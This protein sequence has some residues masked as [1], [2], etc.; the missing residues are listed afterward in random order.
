MKYTLKNIS[1][2]P[3]SKK[4]QEYLKKHNIELRRLDNG[5]TIVG[6][7][8]KMD[9]ADWASIEYSFNTGSHNNLP[10]QVH[11]LEHFFNKKIHKLAEKNDININAY[12]S[13]VGV[14]QTSKG[15]CNPNVTNFGIWKT[16]QGVRSGLENPIDKDSKI[17]SE[18]KVIAD[19]IIRLKNN[20]DFL[21][22]R[23]FRQVVYSKEN[24]LFD[25]PL[26]TG[27]LEDLE[28]IDF[29][30]LQ[31]ITEKVLVPDGMVIKIY[32][33]GDKYASKMLADR[34]ENLYLDFP[35]KNKKSS[36]LDQSLRDKLNPDFKPGQIYIQNTN[37]K[38]NRI[39]FSFVWVFK[40]S[41]P[42]I[43]RFALG[44]I[45]SPLF[46]NLHEYSRIAGWGYQ[47]DVYKIG[48]AHV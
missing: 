25:T 13:Q 9:N 43:E 18:K 24:P 39:T 4:G 14:S 33:E 32:T 29:K 28:K 31:S 10:G 46:A 40:V 47:T 45:V 1:I 21:A 23:H 19:E 20:H 36:K 17:E 11:F 3:N 48:R 7:P 30:S 8:C 2:E 12:T 37:I 27:E 26:V 38:N 42:E 35:R 16:L 41:F 6:I 15:V 5:I 44:N 22:G 34:I